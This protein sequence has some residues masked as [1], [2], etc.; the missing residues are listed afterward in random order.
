MRCWEGEAARVP[1]EAGTIMWGIVFLNG[2]RNQPFPILTSGCHTN[3]TVEKAT[4][5]SASKQQNVLHLYSVATF[6]II[7]H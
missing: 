1:V 2:F 3:K 4:A 5:M 7:N 6:P